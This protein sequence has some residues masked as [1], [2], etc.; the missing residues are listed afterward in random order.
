MSLLASAH[1]FA[2]TLPLFEGRGYFFDVTVFS[3]K[4]K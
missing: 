4:G 2:E 3:N 1:T